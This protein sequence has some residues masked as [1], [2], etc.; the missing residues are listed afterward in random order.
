[1]N[2][3]ILVLIGIGLVIS[4]CGGD[5]SLTTV[6]DFDS[7]GN[8]VEV[9]PVALAR[10]AKEQS[11]AATSHRG[12]M[13]MRMT[14][15]PEVDGLVMRMSFEVAA[16][17]DTAAISHW[18][19]DTRD[20]IGVGDS[21]D[22]KSEMR[23]V[24]D[25]LYISWPQEIMEEIATT[26]WA[27]FDIDE[28]TE[29]DLDILRSFDTSTFLNHLIGINDE[30]IITQDED[31][32]GNSATRISGTYTI[33]ELLSS[34]PEDQ[35]QAMMDLFQFGTEMADDVGDLMDALE[36][37]PIQLDVWI[38]QNNYIV[39][40][41]TIMDQWYEYLISVDPSVLFSKEE[42]DNIVQVVDIYFYDYGAPITITTPPERDVT[43]IQGSFAESLL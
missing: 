21:S 37:L 15:L 1:M 36:K 9:N 35:R 27:S 29:V 5:S 14:G 32:N 6:G 13:E 25:L 41:R 8:P 19:D 31:A 10:T 17:G 42:M 34:L 20:G 2:P 33:A 43:H 24:G 3:L 30:A 11:G 16:N 40:Q 22:V 23:F 28:L 7:D 18:A 39:R 38:D 4:G 26:P 12:D